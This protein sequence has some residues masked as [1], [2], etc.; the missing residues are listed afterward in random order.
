MISFLN[1]IFA[2]AFLALTIPL[3]LHFIQSSRTEK[4]PFST[5]RFLKMA[6]KRSSRRVKMENFLLMLL[7]FLLLVLLVLAFMM[8]IVRT[9]KFGNVL[10]RTARDVAI[11]ID[12]SYSM[13]YK[14]NQQVVWN[15]ATELASTVIAGLE[16]NDRFCVY[17]AGDQVTPVFEERMSDNKEEAAIRLKAL[18]PPVGSS[19]LCPATIAALDLMEQDSRRG[20]RELHII[21]DYQKLPWASFK[22][23]SGAAAGS[24]SPAAAGAG[25]NVWDPSKVSDSI[26][27]F[28]TL[29]GTPEPENSSTMDVELSP[30]L[31]TAETPC[32]VTVTLNRTGPPL[33]SVVSIFLDGSEVGRQSVMVGEGGA[34]RVQFMLPPMNGGVHALRV[35]TPEDSLVEDNAFHFLI[36]VREKLPVLCVGGPDN[37]LFLQTALAAGEDGIS[38]INAKVIQ[39]NALSSENIA[40][41]SCIF[42]CNAINLPG[43]QIKQLEG[44]V[45]AGGLLVVFPGNHATLTDYALWATLPAEPV[46]FNELSVDK[47]KRLLTWDQP[48]HPVLWNLVEDGLAPS[49]VI[50]RQ[51]KCETL[52]EKAESIVSTGSGEPFLMM[53][54]HGRGAVI[55]FTVAADRSWSDFPLSPFYLPLMHQLTQYAAGV[56][57]GKPYLWATD[58]LSLTEFLPE[59]TRDS[60][61]KGPKGKPVSLR[62]AVVEGGNVIYAEGLTQPGIY[63]LS[64]PG[65]GSSKPALAINMPRVESD[66]NPVRQQDIPDILGIPSL[67][68]ANSKDDLLKKLDDFRIGRSLGETLLWLA[69]LIAIAEVL[70]SNFLLRKNSKLTDTLKVEA[71][72]RM[73]EK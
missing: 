29:L 70:Y 7:R 45:A 69:L 72:G 31:I 12:G 52:K 16:D 25:E 5:L 51:L 6:Q 35:E 20:E 15:Q 54:S 49:L 42:L 46:S 73:K 67:H 65:Q 17:L 43:Q 68:I 50:N 64:I 63:K 18:S 19:K 47:R 60:V 33:D 41:Y 30:K 8:P 22:K 36:R 9:K 23:S 13:N 71:S 1:S 62:S 53:R 55:M 24:A 59:A 34:N 26:T 37:T 10:S 11:V 39:P 27:C 56:G 3:I 28:V 57:A 40:S 44:Y 2:F 4:M 32:R 58:T 61:L 38:P 14:L 21:S 48:Q 66:L